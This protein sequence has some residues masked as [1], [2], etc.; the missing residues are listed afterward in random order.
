MDKQLKN[1]IEIDELFDTFLYQISKGISYEKYSNGIRF[2]TFQNVKEWESRYGY[3]FQIYSND[4]F[5][6]NKPHFHFFN[7]DNTIHAKIDFD[8][9]I[10]EYKTQNKIQKNILKDLI[11]FL[12][13]KEVKTKII[14]I[15]NFSNPNLK[16]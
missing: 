7:N 6:N 4:H 16:V 12:N 10:L 13:L 8:G 9:N 5:I 2:Q 3:K 1:I 11:Y 14:E 15:W